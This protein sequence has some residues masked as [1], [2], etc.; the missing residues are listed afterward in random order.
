MSDAGK[1]SVDPAAIALGTA[2]SDLSDD[3]HPRVVKER[4]ATLLLCLFLLVGLAFA[5]IADSSS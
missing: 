4:G 3:L 1:K 2:R 5:A